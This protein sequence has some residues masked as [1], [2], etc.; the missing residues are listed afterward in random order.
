[1][2]FGLTDEQEQLAAAERSWLSRNDP[3]A[4]IRA[5]GDSAP[6]IDEAGLAHAAESGLIAVLTPTVGGTHVDLGVVSEV[7]GAAASSVP[8][9]DL[10]VATTLLSEYGAPQAESAAEG[11]LPLVVA[12]GPQ[13][14]RSQDALMLRGHS[15]PAPGLPDVAGLVLV[16]AV[17]P[18]DST[19]DGSEYLVVVEYPTVSTMKTLDLTRSWGKAYVEVT[20]PLAQWVEVPAGT[21]GAIEDA[22]A[23][24][25]AFDAVGGAA[26][27]LELTVDYAQQRQQFGVPIGSFQ[28]IKHHCANM[29]IAVEAGRSALWAA[30]A[31]L[32]DDNPEA[33]RRQVASAAAFAKAAASE[34][35]Q[36]AL[37]VH[38]GIG[39]TWEHDVHLFLRRIKVDEAMNGSVT[40]HRGALVAV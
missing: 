20:V 31:A 26:R 6:G 12:R 40:A 14:I 27:L 16:G 13:A 24:H 8:I 29:A 23:V 17:E 38:G 39:F 5:A 19:D 9:A 22:L 3:I 33:R 21:V 30:A 4:R 36:L 34:V 35:A 10:A 1:M 25:R 15:K 32:D 18:A 11:R 2:D 37:Q 7:H 28:A